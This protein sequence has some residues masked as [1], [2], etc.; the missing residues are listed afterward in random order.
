MGH[1]PP[2]NDQHDIDSRIRG[3]SSESRAATEAAAG[4]PQCGLFHLF[5]SG[6]LLADE[7]C[8]DWSNAHRQLLDV[9]HSQREGKFGGRN[10]TRAGHPSGSG[11]IQATYANREAEERS[12]V[13]LPVWKEHCEDEGIPD[14]LRLQIW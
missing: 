12:G 9:V 6:Y 7:T 1:F 5:R 8:G 14:V 2:G 4:L 13:E 3:L 11:R 10:G